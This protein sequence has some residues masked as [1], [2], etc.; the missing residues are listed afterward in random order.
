MMTGRLRGVLRQLR[1]VTA[2][3]L[4]DEPTDGALLERFRAGREELA[5]EALVRRHRELVVWGRLTHCSEGAHRT[6]APSP[7]GGA[8][9]AGTR[10]RRHRG[11]RL[12]RVAA[13]P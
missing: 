13:R 5:F 2:S 3:P 10:G 9:H 7:S 6:G 8:G 4:Q 1:R 11:G 12:A